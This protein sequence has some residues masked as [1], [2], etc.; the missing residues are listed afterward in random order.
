MAKGL[1]WHRE[2]VWFHSPNFHF[3]PSTSL[4][5]CKIRPVSCQNSTFSSAR[6]VKDSMLWFGFLVGYQVFLFHRQTLPP[7]TSVAGWSTVSSGPCHSW[8][9]TLSDQPSEMRRQKTRHLFQV[10][11]PGIGIRF[12]EKEA[13]A[14]SSIALTDLQDAP[15]Y[16]PYSSWSHLEFE[17]L[18][19]SFRFSPIKMFECLTW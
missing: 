1:G 19:S 4:C 16:Q 12:K 13:E 6:K 2:C 5:A 14:R 8:N 18:F 3:R 11:I 15:W 17:I 7:Y 10:L 9:A